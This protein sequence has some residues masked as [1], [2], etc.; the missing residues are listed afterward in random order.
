M[1]LKGSFTS[2]DDI[3]AEFQPTIFLIE[4]TK[5]SLKFWRGDDVAA[6]HHARIASAKPD[7]KSPVH[8]TSFCFFGALVY[9]RRYRFK[10]GDDRL[11]KGREM[12]LQME[13]WAKNSPA[14][15]G[16]KSLLLKAE[17][18]ASVNEDSD[19]VKQCY[20]DAN[21]TARDHGNIHD[22][23]L[24]HELLGNY[25]ASQGQMEDSNDCFLRAFVYFRQWGAAAVAERIFC[26]YGLD[27]ASVSNMELQIGDLKHSRFED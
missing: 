22:L 10:G 24:G 5:L 18:A 6:E 15:F 26:D 13:D 12:L 23:A 20:N 14:T 1:S 17:H 21:R 8:Y 4:V 3:Q 16:S 27:N 7:K 19:V 9:F 2:L 11:E 25:C